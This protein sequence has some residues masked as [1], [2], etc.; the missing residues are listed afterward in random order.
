MIPP[1]DEPWKAG[2][3]IGGK[4]ELNRSLGAGATGYFYRATHTWTGR[5]VA[6]KLLRQDIAAD[7][8]AVG[9]FVREARAAARIAHPNIIDVLDMGRD[10]AAG[11]FYIAQEYLVGVDLRTAMSRRPRYEPRAAADILVPVMGALASAHA[12]GVVHR[13]LKPENVFLADLEDG[14]V[15]PKVIDFGM[16]KMLE[17]DTGDSSKPRTGER[18]GNVEYLAP[19]QARGEK[20]VDGRA[21]IWSVGVLWYRML[22]GKNPFTAAN[23]VLSITKI[24][25]DDVRRL[26][27]IVPTVPADL[28]NIVHRA[29][30]RDVNRRYATMEE[31]LRSVLDCPAL[32]E[33]TP[34]DSLR[35]RHRASLGVLN[36][37]APES[38]A[39]IA[40]RD[41]RPSAQ[42]PAPIE[43]ARSGEL[44]STLTF[45]HAERTSAPPDEPLAAAQGDAALASTQ[46]GVAL[47]STQAGVVPALPHAG[48]ALASTEAGDSATTLAA[49]AQLTAAQMHITRGNVKEAEQSA[50]AAVAGLARGS[51]DWY[52]AVTV[53]GRA[54]AARGHHEP[55]TQIADEMIAARGVAP[56]GPAHIV[57]AAQLSVFLLWAGWPELARTLLDSIAADGER[58]AS[59]DP[60][61]RGCLERARAFDL[62]HQGDLGA[63]L[64]YRQ[65]AVASFTVAHDPVGCTTELA[66]LGDTFKELG[67]WEMAERTLRQAVA[68]SDE[69][70]LSLGSVARANLG[71]VLARAGRVDEARVL[72]EQAVELARAQQNHRFHGYAQLYV[73]MLELESGRFEAALA[74]AKL[75]CEISR[76]L[77]APRAVGLAVQ[78]QALLGLGQVDAALQASSDAV[79]VSN[80]LGGIGEGEAR[81]WLA[82]AEALFASGHDDAGREEIARARTRLLERAERIRDV[83]WR[84]SFL[85]YVPENARILALATERLG[86]T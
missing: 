7:D 55:V 5:E 52:A 68:R 39:A 43:P 2:T 17:S 1:R 31:F 78:A 46:G 86:A 22:A 79:D 72:L 84:T 66:N 57:A 56:A 25:R 18:G 15:E 24:V 19:E 71:I 41:A 14:T 27:R 73:A 16:A 49:R 33:S 30:E 60:Y 28:A 51:D 10:A 75:A 62:G 6:I 83:H 69:H 35:T 8:P 80:L 11:T 21:D 76:R 65:A 40:M 64:R 3:L 23:I 37:P 26:E 74:A 59:Y 48:G 70:Q 50:R 12:A 53:L 20:N 58:I 38:Q 4:Y 32:A 77:T 42:P 54:L 13:D 47:A 82:S 67:A 34:E 44:S 9:R 81:I 45:A 63:T 36:A 29:L 85:E 61:V